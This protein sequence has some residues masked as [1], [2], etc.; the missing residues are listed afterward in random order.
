MQLRNAQGDVNQFNVISGIAFSTTTRSG[1]ERMG[2]GLRCDTT[3]CH[4]WK[5]RFGGE[6]GYSQS[7]F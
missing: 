5:M 4:E 3:R 7:S 6:G 2:L 1:K